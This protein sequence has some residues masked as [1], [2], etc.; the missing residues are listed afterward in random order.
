[1]YVWY[2]F[3]LNNEQGDVR[4]GE[5]VKNIELGDTHELKTKK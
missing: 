1:M 2:P 4:K 3:L 5:I